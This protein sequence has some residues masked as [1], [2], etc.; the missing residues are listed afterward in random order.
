M[1]TIDDVARKAGV[2]LGTVSNVLNNPE[3]VKPATRD[4]VLKIIEETGFHPNLSARNL[5]RSKTDTIALIYPFSQRRRTEHYYS[6]FLAGTTDTCFRLNYR[7]MLSSYPRDVS[8]KEKLRNYEEL[9]NGSAVDG[10]VITRTERN[11]SAIQLLSDRQQKF[12]ALGRCDLPIDFPW[13]D[14]DGAKAVR[15]AVHYLYNLGHRRIAYVGTPAL[16]TFSLHRSEGYRT[17][18]E[19]VGIEF[20]EDLV[21]L[22]S[23]AGNEIEAGENGM[24]GFLKVEAPPSAVIVGGGQLAIGVVNGIE[25]SGYR[26]GTDISVISFDDTDWSTHYSPPITT[27]R[28]PLYEMG[29]LVA[30]LLIKSIAGEEPEDH[31]ILLNTEL[32]IRGSCKKV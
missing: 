31:H 29:K 7:L 2:S 27:I 28:Q 5:S 8:E 19:E 4:R 32:V 26:V 23:V 18:L 3:K 22:A 10:I 14:V 11:D 25:K 17:G 9:T 24:V 20:D 1:P 13:V 16:F 21:I 6:D 12:A 30:E 15:E